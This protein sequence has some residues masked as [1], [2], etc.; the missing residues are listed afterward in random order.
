MTSEE[1][2]IERARTELSTLEK[3][4]ARR[5]QGI[6]PIQNRID[7]LKGFLNIDDKPVKTKRNGTRNKR[8]SNGKSGRTEK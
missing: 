4:L 7:A 3:T 1:R 2:D 8:E 6:K 5:M